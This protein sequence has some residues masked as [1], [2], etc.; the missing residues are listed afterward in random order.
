T[1]VAALALANRPDELSLLLV[2]YK[3]G[4]AFTDAARLPHTVGLITDLDEQLAERALSSLTAELK[5]RERQLAEVGATDLAGY[6]SSSS[7]PLARL[8][9]LVDEFRALADELPGFLDGLVRLAAQGRSLG[10]H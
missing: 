3:G 8:V 4:S 6:R 10:M 2:D 5:R 7:D 9:I 1:I